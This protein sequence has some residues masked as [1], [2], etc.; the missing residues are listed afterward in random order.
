MKTL[1]DK[2]CAK[3]AHYEYEGKLKVDGWKMGRCNHGKPLLHNGRFNQF[4]DAGTNCPCFKPRPNP[5]Q[6]VVFDFLK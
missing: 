5:F 2:C 1:P 6:G 3:C 4:E